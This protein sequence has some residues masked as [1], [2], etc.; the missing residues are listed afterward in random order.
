MPQRSAFSPRRR[1]W[2]EAPDEGA[3]RASAPP[4]GIRSKLMDYT[5]RLA[6]LRGR[7]Q[8]TRT[9]TVA[10]GPSS[11]MLWLS[12]LSPHGD[13]RPVL[14]VV[15]QDFAGMLLLVFNAD[16]S[17]SVLVLLFFLWFV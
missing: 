9:D 3:F 2:R 13:E 7:M 4:H 5:Q 16:S 11:H 6:R 17:R 14:L 1:R 8:S 12:G 15:T 10:L